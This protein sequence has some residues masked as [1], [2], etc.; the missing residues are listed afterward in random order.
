MAKLHSLGAGRFERAASMYRAL[1][2]FFGVLI[3]VAGVS[4]G[5]RLIVIL[6]GDEYIDAVDCLRLLV[7]GSGVH[8]INGAYV[9]PMLVQ[10]EERRV[11]VA[12]A[13]AT[14]VTVSTMWLT[15]ES[16]GTVGAAASYVFGI[17]VATVCA[18]VLTSGRKNK[19]ASK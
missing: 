4:A 14:S 2:T 15:V 6:F 8:V 17:F 10:G 19:G 16:F 12:L 7:I 13:I 5:D 1:F 3:V 11:L 9:Q 18:M